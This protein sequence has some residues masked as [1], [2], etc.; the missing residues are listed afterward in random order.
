MTNTPA[1]HST[2][3]TYKHAGCG[4]TVTKT[5]TGTVGLVYT[6]LHGWRSNCGK[7]GVK[8]ERHIKKENANA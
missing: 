5:P 8:V 2:R 6:G 3:Y 4:C 7:Y 1:T